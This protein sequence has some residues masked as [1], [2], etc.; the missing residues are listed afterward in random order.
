MKMQK[1]PKNTRKK[2]RLSITSKSKDQLLNYFVSR[3]KEWEKL[4]IFTPNPEFIVY[5][6]KDRSFA[7]I[8]KSAD[9]LLPDGSFLVWALEL[10]KS[11]KEGIAFW[12]KGFS[13][14]FEV[15]L[16]RL[17]EKRVTGAD[18]MLDLC[19]LAAERGL[20]V[21]FLGGEE[22]V[23]AVAARRIKARTGGKLRVAGVFSGD[24][25]PKGD[26]ET[27][28]AIKKAAKKEA[29]GTID[30]LFIAYGMG[31]QERW[32]ERN[33]SKIP[34]KVAM[35]VGGSFDYY[36]KVPRAPLWFRRHGLEWFYRLLKQPWRV[37][38]QFKL[39]RF[40]YLIL[41]RRVELSWK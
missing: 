17:G 30:I 33:L 2:L 38:R 10:Q 23:A 19:F 37:R 8:L 7:K 16:G 6:E 25:S 27:T 29:S 36:V 24:G 9:V 5:A 26:Q 22:G 15:F 12:L 32:I 35:G 4:S 11:S 41:A 14:A 20:S 1:N 13:L 31:K 18:F 28:L 34:V 40:F 21:F 3:V 39:W